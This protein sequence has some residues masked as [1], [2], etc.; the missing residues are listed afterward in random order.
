MGGKRPDQY[1]LDPAE[2]GATDYKSRRYDDEITEQEKQKVT[3]SGAKIPPRGENPALTD[4]REKR[5]EAAKRE[6]EEGAD[7]EG[8]NEQGASED[9]GDER[10]F[11]TNERGGRQA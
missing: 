8:E 11:G 5:A 4:L 10:D 6:N 3:G 2:A 7:A 1:R 9:S